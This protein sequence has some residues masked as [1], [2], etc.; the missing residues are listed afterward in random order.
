MF[1]TLRNPGLR[2]VYFILMFNS[3]HVGTTK[4][5]Y[6]V[7]LCLSNIILVTR[8]VSAINDTTVMVKHHLVEIMTVLSVYSKHKLTKVDKTT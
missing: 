3:S 1:K 6:D 7:V 2:F 5:Y 4:Y 8:T